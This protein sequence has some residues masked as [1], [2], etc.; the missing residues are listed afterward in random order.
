MKLIQT[1]LL[2]LA[3]LF[4]STFVHAAPNDLA[5]QNSVYVLAQNDVRDPA[6]TRD[7]NLTDPQD[8]RSDDQSIRNIDQSNKNSSGIT[9]AGIQ[10][11]SGEF[12]LCAASSC[13]RTG[14]EIEVKENGGQSVKKFPEVVCKCPIIDKQIAVLNGS[15]LKGIA[16]VNEGNMR[17]SCLAPGPDKIW[18]LFAPLTYYPQESDDFKTREFHQQSCSASTATGSNCFSFLCTIDKTSTNGVRTA[19]C[20]CPA[21]ENPFGKPT[22]NSEF[23][24]AAGAYYPTSKGGPQAA[25]SQYPVSIPNITDLS[26]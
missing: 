6:L 3:T 1:L 7:R 5:S 21:G 13:V 2:S 18:S 19:S 4:I 17:G 11:C 10:T 16:A 20:Y 23:L 22:Q 9:K 8:R 15:E 26:K 14:K 25:C 24:T 12:A